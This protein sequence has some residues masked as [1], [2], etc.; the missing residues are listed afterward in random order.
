MD[1]EKKE[2]NKKVEKTTTI[3]DA[4]RENIDVTT[5]NS[6]NITDALIIE[7]CIFYVT[8]VELTKDQINKIKSYQE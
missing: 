1:N 2:L 7:D 8:N 3:L 6:I 4:T 5:L